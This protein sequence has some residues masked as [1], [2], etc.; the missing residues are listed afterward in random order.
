MQ[1]YYI[2]YDY[3]D[4]TSIKRTRQY[5]LKARMGADTLEEMLQEYNKFK[6]QLEARGYNGRVLGLDRIDQEE[7]LTKIL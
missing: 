3:D 2:L 6:D 4:G 1:Q 5:A 7:I